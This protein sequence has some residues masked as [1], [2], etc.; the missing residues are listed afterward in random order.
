MIL[1]KCV[2]SSVCLPVCLPVFFA[3]LSD[4]SRFR[5]FVRQSASLYVCLIPCL[6]VSR[7][8]C[9]VFCRLSVCLLT[10]CLRPFVRLSVSPSA[11]LYVQMNACL[12]VSGFP[13]VSLSVCRSACLCLCL[14]VRPF[15]CLYMSVLFLFFCHSLGLMFSVRLSVYL[16][17]CLSVCLSF[18]PFVFPCLSVRPAMALSCG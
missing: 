17:A 15:V 7:S 16:L 12:C 9:L 8:L 5:S 13:F 14:F 3:C 2:C 11:C 10:S 1:V 18:F 4:S 6:L